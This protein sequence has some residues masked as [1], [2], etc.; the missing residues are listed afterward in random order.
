MEDSE[1]LADWLP[2]DEREE[3]VKSLRGAFV[4]T[5]LILYMC[6]G[7]PVEEGR[8]VKGTDPCHHRQEVQ[9]RGNDEEEGLEQR[10]P[11]LLD[12][13]VYGCVF[14]SECACSAREL[15]MMIGLLGRVDC[16]GHITPMM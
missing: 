15:V 16:H 9:R 8:D 2:K 6:F 10:Q 12:P 5:M 13:G 4:G 7:F 1:W 11:C 14:G 3:E